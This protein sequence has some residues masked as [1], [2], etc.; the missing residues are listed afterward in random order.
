M[1]QIGIQHGNKT[2]AQVAI[3][4]CITKGTLPIPGARNQRQAKE[5]AGALGWSLS[6]EQVARLDE[7]SGSL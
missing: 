1:G 3:N 5:N 7:V 2:S 6:D 4:W